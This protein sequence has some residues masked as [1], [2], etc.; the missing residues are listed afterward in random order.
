MLPYKL[1]KGYSGRV[2][3]H[4][5]FH[6]ALRKWRQGDAIY[7]LRGGKWVIYTDHG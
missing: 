2:T 6:A 1:I 3:Y 7:V 5:T 4:K